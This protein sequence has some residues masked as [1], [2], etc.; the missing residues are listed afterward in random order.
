MKALIYVVNE[1]KFH[2][3]L[4]DLES[5]DVHTLDAESLHESISLVLWEENYFSSLDR[6]W[7]SL[8]KELESPEHPRIATLWNH[9]LWKTE[10]SISDDFKYNWLYQSHLHI[11]KS[12]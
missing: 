4:T 7:D 3:D 11:F 10:K 6:H 1:K 8:S 5:K 12:F 2:Q 9:F